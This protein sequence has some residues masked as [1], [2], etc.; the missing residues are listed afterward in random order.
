MAI[1]DNA[2]VLK[3]AP[4]SPPFRTYKHIFEKISKDTTDF[5]YYL[6]GLNDVW[7]NPNI[8]N[9]SVYNGHQVG[10]EYADKAV[11]P[12]ELRSKKKKIDGSS[13]KEWSP[14]DVKKR[15]TAGDYNYIATNL[16]TV[17]NKALTSK[18][19]IDYKAGSRLGTVKAGDITREPLISNIVAILTEI[20]NTINTYANYWD[21]NDTCARS[22]QLNCQVGCQVMCQS[23]VSGNCHHQHCGA[24]S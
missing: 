4:S 5:N 13:P 16:K 7:D 15:V 23:C 6:L 17:A 10:Y 9:P 20:Q 12:V 19:K 18:L 3:E 2:L 24:C 22:C 21:A 8:Y 11:V 14:L 1:A